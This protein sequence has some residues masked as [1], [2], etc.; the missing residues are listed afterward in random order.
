MTHSVLPLLSLTLASC[1][2]LSREAPPLASRA[3]T[4]GTNGPASL[5][6]SPDSAR[7][8]PFVYPFIEKVNQLP[9]YS[10]LWIQH[11]PRYHVVA[12]FTRPPPLGEVQR[13]APRQI[14]D[15][16]EVRTAKRSREEIAGLR[17]DIAKRLQAGR[18]MGWS[19]GYN[20]KTQCFEISVASPAAVAQV[21][22]LLTPEQLVDADIRVGPIPQPL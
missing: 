21:R 14:R 7:L 9:G 4:P 3:C 5:G 19:G 15:R 6:I 11:Q 10:G 22:E 1:S 20:P 18:L 8:E 12:T 16:I 2:E 13:L 17:D